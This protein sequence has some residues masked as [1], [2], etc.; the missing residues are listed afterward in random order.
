MAILSEQGVSK[1][2]P[3]NL[4]IRE[5]ILKKAKD[6]SLN[7]SKAAE[8]GILLAIKAEREKQWLEENKEAISAHNERIE[9]EGTL[10]KPAWMDQ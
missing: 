2:R 1:R 9:R 3:V 10:L 8:Y 4:T 5:D 7:A 6:L